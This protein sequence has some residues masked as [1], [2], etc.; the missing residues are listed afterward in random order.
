M[1][2]EKLHLPNNLKYI[3]YG[4]FV[5]FSCDELWI[6]EGVEVVE[7][8][9]IAGYYSKIH[10]PKSIKDISYDFYFE[11]MITDPEEW[12]PYVEIHPDNPV[13]YS[14]DGILYSRATGKEVLGEAG[15]P[16]KER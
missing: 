9:S 11:E 12:K 13:Y 2:I 7:S 5:G 3:R 8:W 1:T 15:R 16:E 6:P 14:K 4:A 10:F